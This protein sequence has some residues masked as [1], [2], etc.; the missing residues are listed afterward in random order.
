MLYKDGEKTKEHTH[1]STIYGNV[2]ASETLHIL[3]FKA[4]S[5]YV[6]YYYRWKR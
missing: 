2:F 1:F 4:R 5:C 3:N 6:S